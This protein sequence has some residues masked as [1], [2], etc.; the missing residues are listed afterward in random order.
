M[1]PSKDWYEWAKQFPID[2]TTGIQ[3]TAEEAHEI[4]LQMLEEEKTKHDT[5]HSY[6][7]VA[8][9]IHQKQETDFLHEG[10][11]KRFP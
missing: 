2:N 9:A 5:A 8:S 1:K 7:V 3:I 11:R 6:V 10:K 4:I